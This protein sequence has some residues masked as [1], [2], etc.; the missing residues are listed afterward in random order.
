MSHNVG[1]IV[2]LPGTRIGPDSGTPATG[3]GVWEL[4]FTPQPALTGGV[5]RFVLLHLNAISLR[6]RRASRSS[7]GTPRTSS[8]RLLARTSGHAPL[9]LP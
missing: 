9:T 8:R 2:A 4:Q 6:G 1:R 3:P 7:W 5:P